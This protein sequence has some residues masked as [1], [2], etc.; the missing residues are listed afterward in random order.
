MNC[1]ANRYPIPFSFFSALARFSSHSYIQYKK[2]TEKG[3][4]AR[5]HSQIREKKGAGLSIVKGEFYFRSSLFSQSQLK[6]WLPKGPVL[7]ENL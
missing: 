2:K 7:D 5:D 3:I 1:L 4:T 6:L